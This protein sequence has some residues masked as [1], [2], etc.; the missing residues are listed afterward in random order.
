MLFGFPVLEKQTNPQTIKNHTKQ[1]L[2]MSVNFVVLF[3]KNVKL[4]AA[5]Y[6]VIL[7]FVLSDFI[8]IQCAVHLTGPLLFVCVSIQNHHC[9]ARF[10]AHCYR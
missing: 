3:I 5:E 2:G 6:F 4:F 8:Y 7:L 1:K 9:V 10:A